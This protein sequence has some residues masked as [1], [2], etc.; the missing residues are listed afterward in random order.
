MGGWS[1]EWVVKWDG[2]KLVCGPSMCVWS[3]CDQSI[4]MSV[5]PKCVQGS[6]GWVVNWVGGQVGGWVVKWVGVKWVGGE[7]GVWPKC[8]CVWSVCGQSVCMHVWP[9]CVKGSSGWVVIW[10]GDR[11][12][13]GGGQV[14]GYEVDVWP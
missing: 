7:V 4:C 5:W 6:S 8:V 10:M 2:V 11:V 1:S 3:V 14:G 13:G 9:K 12:G